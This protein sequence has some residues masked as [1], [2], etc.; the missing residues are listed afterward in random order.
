MAMDYKLT[1]DLEM[2]LLIGSPGSICW[3]K[4]ID[5]EASIV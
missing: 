3:K 1:L 4:G 2:E 5:A